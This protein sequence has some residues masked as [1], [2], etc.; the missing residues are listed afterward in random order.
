MKGLGFYALKGKSLKRYMIY[1]IFL[2]GCCVSWLITRY[3]MQVE[4]DKTTAYARG[5][6]IVAS[7]L[8]ELRRCFDTTE[9]MNDLYKVNGDLF[10]DNFEPICAELLEDN[11]AIGSMYWAPNGVIR[12]AYP[13]EVTE[14]TTNFEMLKDPIQGPKSQLALESRKAT[15]AGPH[16]LIEGGKGFIIRNPNYDEEGNFLAFSIMVIDLELFKKQVFSGLND[17][18][19]QYKFAVWKKEDATASYEEGGYIFTNHGPIEKREI[20]IN[21]AAP[22]DEWYLT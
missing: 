5:E 10:L 20:Q 13:D 7:I 12:Y 18:E 4:H 3:E 2:V 19:K 17:E 16:D 11:L 1:S 22:N 8:T 21:F 6:G 15:I 9:L 14:S